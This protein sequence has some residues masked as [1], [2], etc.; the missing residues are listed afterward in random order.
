[1]PTEVTRDKCD[2]ADKEGSRYQKWTDVKTVY[3][4]TEPIYHMWKGKVYQLNAD[5]NGRSMVCLRFR[6]K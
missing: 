1:M 5:Y 4:L 6:I 3:P 2:E